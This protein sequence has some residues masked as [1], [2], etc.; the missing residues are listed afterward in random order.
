[1]KILVAED[2]KLSRKILAEMLA[3]WGHEIVTAANGAEA[4]KIL[5]EEQPPSVVILDWIMPVLNGL[6][7][8]KFIRKNQAQHE[9]TYVLILTAR[10]AKRDLLLA[11]EAGADDYIQKPVDEEELQVRLRVAT[12]ILT[13]QQSLIE[14]ASNDALTGLMN[15]GSILEQFN[16]EI[17]RARRERKPLAIIVAD[18]D[19]FKRINDTYGH[20]IGDDVLIEAAKRLRSAMRRYD[21][22]GRYGGEEFLIVLPGCSSLDA[23]RIADR[24]RDAVSFFPAHTEEHTIPF[25]ISMGVACL[26]SIL[27]SQESLIRAAD[28]ALYVAK[29]NGRDRIEMAWRESVERS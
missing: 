27:D 18:L 14:K 13:L 8:C 20:Q 21:H 3:G 6:E 2:D 28:Q 29:R 23:Y 25:T 12:R 17:H 11:M 4:I 24:I 9:Y 5:C 19:H 15:H 22:V 16:K 26:D 7:A 10:T 1:M